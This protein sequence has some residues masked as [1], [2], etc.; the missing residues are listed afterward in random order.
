MKVAAGKAGRRFLY[1]NI[2]RAFRQSCYGLPPRLG[3]AEVFLSF[4]IYSESKEEL[5]EETKYLKSIVH[6]FGDLYNISLGGIDDF[7]KERYVANGVLLISSVKR[8]KN[9][10]RS[11]VVFSVEKSI[12][13]KAIYDE[14][15]NIISD[16]IITSLEN[17]YRASLILFLKRQKL[18]TDAFPSLERLRKLKE[19]EAFISTA[20]RYQDSGMNAKDFI[21]SVWEPWIREGVLFQDRLS[22]HDPKIIPAL[23]SYWQSRRRPDDFPMPLPKKARTDFILAVLRDLGLLQDAVRAIRNMSQRRNPVRTQTRIRKSA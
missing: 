17:S 13:N 18:I 12:N 1:A 5:E 16:P 11:F 2:A 23:H 8:N 22:E 9:A 15:I 6:G 7:E 4:A 20:P 10:Y 19:L 14:I 21:L 3:K